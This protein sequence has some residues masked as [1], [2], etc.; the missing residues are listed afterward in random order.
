MKCKKRNRSSL[1]RRQST[2]R[3]WIALSLACSCAGS[4]LAGDPVRNSFYLQPV[5]SHGRA[6]ANGKTSLET[7][8]ESA[9]VL[10][11]PVQEKQSSA[12]SL[13]PRRLPKTTTVRQQSSTGIGVPVVPASSETFAQDLPPQHEW[14]ALDQP[15]A[16]DSPSEI[17]S[18]AADTNAV[19]KAGSL[20]SES[21]SHAP[22]QVAARRLAQL[23]QDRLSESSDSTLKGNT[24]RRWLQSVTIDSCSARSEQHLAD[25][26]REYRVGAW[27]SAEASAWKALELIATGIDIADR[28]TA[29][30]N[31]QP[32]AA[33]QLRTAKTAMIE[34]RDFLSGGAAIDVDRINAI[35]TSHQTPIFA[36]GVPEGITTT[37]AADR[38]LD[39][40]RM[41]L[42]PLAKYHVMAAQAMD[43][44]AAIELGRNDR[45]HLPEETS[46][47]LRRAALQGQPE[48]AS[49]AARLGM[50]LAEMGLDRE[51]TW[52]LKHA[53]D[54]QPN[55]GVA[56]TL[57]TVQQRQGDREAAMRL[58]AS[59]RMQMPQT[60]KPTRTPE[61]IE[62]SPSQFAAISP[63]F[64]VGQSQIANQPANAPAIA[65]PY[66]SSTHPVS[67][68]NASVKNE[69]ATP[70]VTASFRRPRP[71]QTAPEI[72]RANNSIQAH[73]ASQAQSGIKDQPASQISPVKRFMTKMRFW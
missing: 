6:I 17:A 65:Q 20:V 39:Y 56:A 7:E 50:Q 72:S 24:D 30:S 55:A 9:I 63:A 12:E 14:I 25:A 64:N 34:A 42:A 46:L 33:K 44:V 8:I 47:C 35:A 21:H 68:I 26:Y 23:R 22:I 54:L 48:N 28:Q 41:N 69:D 40:A 36:G 45:S 13:M 43:L 61:V 66:G 11:G 62:L 51:A 71:T 18:H 1:A 70:A 52:T 49:L 2:C 32:R 19:S 58:T 37:E 38:Y 29:A 15:P 10:E 3:R 57:A 60:E 73:T 53:M 67:A 4:V 59:L 31:T 5:S 16:P 27:S